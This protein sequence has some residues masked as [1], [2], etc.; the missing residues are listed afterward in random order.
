MWFFSR[1]KEEY[2]NEWQPRDFKSLLWLPIVFLLFFYARNKIGPNDDIPYETLHFLLMGISFIL[3]GKALSI[4]FNL[5]WI[6]SPFRRKPLNF[7][8]PFRVRLLGVVLVIIGILLFIFHT[9][10]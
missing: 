4:L 7:M 6:A 5:S 3:S 1:D 8:T 2:I 10:K 9:S